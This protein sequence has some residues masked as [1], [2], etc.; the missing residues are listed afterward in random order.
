MNATIQGTITA[1]GDSTINQGTVGGFTSSSSG[2]SSN[3]VI[4][5]SI[6]YNGRVSIN[7]STYSDGP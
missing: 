2:L 5:S 7:S 3:D 6:G 1:T 4:L